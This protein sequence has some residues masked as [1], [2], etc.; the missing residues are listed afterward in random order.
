MKEKHGVSLDK[1]LERVGNTLVS[2][3]NDVVPNAGTYETIGG[4]H[5]YVATPDS[6]Y[7][8]DKIILYLTDGLGI[9]LVNNRVSNTCYSSVVTQYDLPTCFYSFSRTHLRKMVSRLSCLT[10]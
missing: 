7:P 9:P 1:L 3:T 5:C 2:L 4:V 6:D 10:S 8:R